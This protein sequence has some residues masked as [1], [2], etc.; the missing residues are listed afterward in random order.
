MKARDAVYSLWQSPISEILVQTLS[1]LEQSPTIL[2]RCLFSFW[3][4]FLAYSWGLV[5][6]KSLT[7]GHQVTMW[8]ELFIMSWVLSDSPSHKV[9][10]AQ[11][12]STFKLKWNICDRAWVGPE[13][14]DKLHEEVVQMSVAPIPSIL[15]SVSQLAWSYGKF[16]TI[17]W[18]RK[19]RL[20]S[21][22]QGVLYDMQTPLA[23][24]E[25]KHYNHFLGYT[26]RIM[27][28]EN[29]SGGQNFE[30]YTFICLE[31]EM[32]RHM[33][34][35]QFLVLHHWFGWMIEDLER[36]KLEK[37]WQGDLEKSYVNRPLWMHKHYKVVWISCE[38][39]PK[40]DYMS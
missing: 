8:H 37:W 7:M 34:I 33:K 11:Q 29:P 28:K 17:S 24:R 20:R 13:G 6:I 21:D 25:L 4:I 19:R 39:A 2:H 14:I 38:W 3:K 32:A 22:M 31:G 16:P 15:P 12:Y 36:R 9:A 5:E 10:H 1:I 40:A 30:E 26:W 23:S 35:Y 27:E 18:Q